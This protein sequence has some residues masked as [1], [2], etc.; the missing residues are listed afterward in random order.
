MTEHA[1]D[2]R[3]TIGVD[4]H[5]DVH[6]A[7]A[8]DE[9]GVRLGEIHVPTTL[10]GYRQLERWAV[11]LGSVEVFGIEGTGSYGAGLAR[12]LCERGQRVVEVNRPDRATRHR[13]GKS[14]PIDAEMAARAVLSGV[15]TGTPKTGEGSVEMIRMLKIA[16]DSAVKAR[17]QSLNQIR[18]L[19][20]TAPAELRESL[21]GLTVGQLLER[22]IAF[23]PGALSSPAAVA[24]HSLRLLARRNLRLRTE[25]RELEV[26]IRRQVASIAPD[27]LEAF[28]VGP[29]GAATFLLTA[30][31]NPERLRSEAAF[32]ALCGASPIPASSG[33][34][35][36]HRLNRGGDRQANAALHRIVVVRLR[37]HALQ[38][39]RSQGPRP[40]VRHGSV[41]LV[42]LEVRPS[43]D[44]E[45]VVLGRRECPPMGHVRTVRQAS[46]S[47]ECCR[48]SCFGLIG[49][50][51]D[52]DVGPATPRLGRAE[53]LERHVRV[54]SVPIDDVFFRSKAPV[55]EGC[56]PERTY[57]AA[58]I[59]CH[60]NAH[61]LDLGGVGLDLQP[62]S[63][64]R[65]LACQLDIT[66]AQSFV[67]PGCGPDCD[68]LGSHV[69][70]GEVA[71]NLRNFGDRGHNPCCLRERSDVEVGV[72]AREKDPPVL[73]S[74]GVVEYPSSR[75]LLAHGAMPGR[76]PGFMQRAAALRK[77]P[78]PRAARAMS[79]LAALMIAPK[80]CS[81]VRFT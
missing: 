16:R 68:S 58:C 48:D 54:T 37:W 70:V 74:D 43:R 22:C 47:F 24:R 13:L 63:F 40:S 46:A 6:V 80:S 8:L 75:S 67:L 55:P 39:A 61:D 29:D 44:V 45:T 17:T 5:L 77:M 18:A 36:R 42:V 19:L 20:V 25:A 52:V 10:A 65:N 30:G 60:C 9:R 79:A 23:R 57:V 3:V 64:C 41:L 31:D 35:T 50:H 49:R 78:R 12:F 71:H 81:D 11:G 76:K 28:G 26:E 53:A 56:G 34:T 21:T 72:G 2:R 38:L 62:P 4:T 1:L 73:D 32:A 15:A 7:V 66:M 51:A 69:H 59:L 33:K 14:D 27:L